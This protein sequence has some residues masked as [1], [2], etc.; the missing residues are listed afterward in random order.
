MNGGYNILLANNTLYRVG[1][2]SHVM[3]VVHGARTCDGNQAQCATFLTQGGWGTTVI[4]GDEP[5]PNRNVFIYNNV[6]VNPEG[7]SSQWQQ[8][9]VAAD[10]IPGVGSN[11]VS[12]SRGKQHQFYSSTSG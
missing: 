3:E 12:P 6:I 11:I 1:A 2:R 8:F 9:A 4:G 5:I 7:A 10:R